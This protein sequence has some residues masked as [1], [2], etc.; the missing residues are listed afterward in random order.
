MA[1]QIVYGGSARRRLEAG[2]DQLADA[3][4]ITLGPKG[5]NVVLGSSWGS[6]T[7]TNDGVTI[8]QEIDLADPLENMG[9]QLVKQVATQ[10]NEAAGDGTTTAIVLAQAMVHEGLRNVAAGANPLAL[11]RGIETATRV[12]VEAIA[13]LAVPVT[14]RSDIEN[15]AAVSGADPLI[16]VVIADAFDKVGPDGVITVDDSNTFGLSLEF[17]DGMQFDKGYI[18]PYFVSDPA[19]QV[20]QLDDCFILLHE[21]KIE[22]ADELLPLLE[23]VAQSG[24]P[25]LVVA[26]DVGVEALAML[27]VNK[28][29]GI[30]TS[31]AV[32]APGFGDR[33]KDMLADLAVLTNAHVI[34]A[35]LGFSLEHATLDMLGHAQSVVV[36]KDDTTIIGGGGDAQHIEAR[37]SQLQ[38]QIEQTDTEWDR[39]QMSTRLAKLSSGVAT[40]SVGAATEVELTELKFRIEDAVA[41]TRAALDEGAVPGGGVALLRARAA[42]ATHQATLA[43]ADEA[44]GARIVWKAL[45]EPLRQIAANAGHEPGTVAHQVE[46]KTGPNGFNA[47]T[48]RFENLTKARIVDPAKVTRAALENAA[49]VVGLIL[50]TEALLADA[51][52]AVAAG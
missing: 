41:A 35:D 8:A 21:S 32:K 47:A 19:Q 34:S 22:R 23:L 40:V 33:R 39:E 20:A 44:T 4:K 25:L 24:K 45:A 29:Q 7:V 1:K 12:A 37:I 16:G 46:H 38:Y 49:S 28:M 26:E 18:S 11:R 9:A 30:F 52:A 43:D 27:V 48:G 2:V 51:P 5:R 50:T 14:A 10:T 17:S 31:V 6:P 42:V 36:S 3:V 13:Q 15:V